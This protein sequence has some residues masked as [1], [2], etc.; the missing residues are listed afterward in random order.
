[1]KDNLNR[2]CTLKKKPSFY[3][4]DEIGEEGSLRLGQATNQ[5]DDTDNILAT[6]SSGV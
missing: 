6:Q 2:K 1:M 4:F 5:E 3:I